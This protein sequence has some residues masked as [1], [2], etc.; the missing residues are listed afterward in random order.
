MNEGKFLKC[1]VLSYFDSKIGPKVIKTVGDEIL[2]EDLKEILQY[3]DYHEKGYFIHEFRK[4]KSANMIFFVES[5]LARGKTEKIMIS[6]VLINED[7][8]PRT[9]SHLLELFVKK[10]KQIKN[11]YKGFYFEENNSSKGQECLI[12]IETLMYDIFNKFPLKSIVI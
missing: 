2:R 9:Y 7:T 8:D 11:V 4:L 3:I 1:L 5:P 6:V 10:F 12:K